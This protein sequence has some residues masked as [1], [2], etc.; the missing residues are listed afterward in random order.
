MITFCAPVDVESTTY[1]TG[2]AKLAT[3]DGQNKTGIVM[4][5]VTAYC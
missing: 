5:P 2:R 4:M 1:E 3:T